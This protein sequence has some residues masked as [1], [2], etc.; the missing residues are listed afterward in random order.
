MNTDSC[1]LLSDVALRHRL[2]NF[3]FTQSQLHSCELEVRVL[4]GEAI[5][6]GHVT[7]WQQ[8]RILTGCCQRV[9]GIRKVVSDISVLKTDLS[10]SRKMTSTRNEHGTRIEHDCENQFVRRS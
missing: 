2:L 9:A 3:L 5:V 1:W 8:E 10:S 4:N 7:S 6:S